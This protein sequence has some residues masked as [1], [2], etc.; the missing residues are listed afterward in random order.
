M[1]P[2]RF[3]AE[4]F[5]PPHATVFDSP[6][7]PQRGIEQVLPGNPSDKAHATLDGDTSFLWNHRDQAALFDEHEQ[8]VKHLANSGR[9]ALEMT[10]QDVGAAGVPHV[11]GHEAMTALRTGP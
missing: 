8:R 11:S 2:V 9:L 4:R 3:R 6:R 10:L 7:Q 5:H 1:D